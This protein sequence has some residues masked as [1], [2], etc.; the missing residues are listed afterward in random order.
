MSEL[1]L[2][3]LRKE[4][5]HSSTRYNL[6]PDEFANTP[7]KKHDRDENKEATYNSEQIQFDLPQSMLRVREEDEFSA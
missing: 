7:K 3:T 2:G 6:N 4:S 1:T 5:I